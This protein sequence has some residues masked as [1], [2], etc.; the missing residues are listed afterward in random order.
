VQSIIRSYTR[1]GFTAVIVGDKDHAEVTG[2]KGYSETP[3]HVI[4]TAKDV[5]ALPSLGKIVVVAQTTQNE[6]VYR[7]VVEALQARFPDV[8][9]FNTVCEATQQRQEEVRSFAGQ[10]DALVV[11]G[12]YH[13]GNTQRLVQISEEQGLPTF[14]VETEK[15]LDKARLSQMEVIAVTAGASTPNWMI[16]NVVKEI[17]G[18]RGRG[19]SLLFRWKHKVFKFL[20]LSNLVLAAGAFSFTYAA[21][22]LSSRI[23]D[24]TLCAISGLYVYAMHVLNRFLDKGASAYNDPERASFLKKH[25]GLLIMSGIA[26]VV[27]AGAL[28]YSIN[29]ITLLALCLL[30]LLGI[31]YSIP[32]VPES[33]RHKYA[34]SKIKDIPGSRSLSESLA[35]VAVIAVLPLLDL[36]PIVWPTE[37][38][39][40]LTVFSIVYVASALFDIFQV[41]GDL[42]VGTETL[43]ITLG[44]RNTLVLL[45]IILLTIGFIL[46]GAPVFG[47][48]GPFSHIILLSLLALF[49]CLTAYE[50]RWLYPGP[51]LEA[52]VEMTF[53]FTGLLAVV[54]QKIAWQP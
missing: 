24:L 38:I 39:S 45:K 42:I 28:S 26:A 47:L 48:A 6:A 20:I 29:T 37:I 31:V 12:A 5:S 4:Q 17:E 53:L 51:A 25:R 7:E 19:E 27:I 21:A 2:L 10:V 43:P 11:V 44:E 36:K 54:W 1:K 14:H 16:N 3:A 52:L 35:W 41:Q 33:M 23:P 15:D 30:S 18:I 22:I 9:V 49:L 46:A 34:Y 32:L 13:S 8:L 40:I 50:K